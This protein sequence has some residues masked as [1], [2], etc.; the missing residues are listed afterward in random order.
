M[1]F[2]TPD[3]I[4]KQL[5]YATGMHGGEIW[6]RPFDNDSETAWVKPNTWER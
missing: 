6:A 2:H 1:G 5:V 4:A 3:G